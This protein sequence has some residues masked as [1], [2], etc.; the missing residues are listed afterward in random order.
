MS[1][2][3]PRLTLA[4]GDLAAAALEGIVP[5]DRYATPLALACAV[6]A[7]GLRRAPAPEAE[8]VDQLLFGEAFEVLD[9]AGGWAWGQARRDGYV[10]FV[11]RAALDR[12]GPRPTHRVSAL[13][14][15]AFA[16][17]AIKSRASGPLSIN[18]LVALGQR[19][20]R[21]GH[22]EG[23]GWLF[24]HQLAPIGQVET[25]F[26]AIAERFV[27]AAY[28]WGGR[29]A[30][31]VDCSGLVQQ[32]LLAC[33]CGCPRDTDLQQGLGAAV[34]AS[35]L[36]RGDL[37]FWRGHVAIMVDASRIVHANGH[38][39]AVVI[40]PLAEATARIFAAGSGQPIAYRRI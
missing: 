27:G 16:E 38:H 11:E 4:R 13:R 17:P 26:V 34:E 29:E 33:G 23:L 14:A 19:E 1:A 22:V 28:L 15:Y 37:V 25:D 18:A 6:P 31:G 9:E 2:L 24:E 8:Q 32:A 36:R 30:E 39:A 21:F 3:D 5:A 10:G 7:T 35:A 40:E 20:G 12:P